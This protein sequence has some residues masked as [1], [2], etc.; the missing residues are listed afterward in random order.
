[1][2]LKYCSHDQVYQNEPEIGEV[3]SKVFSEGEIKRED[4]FITSKL[5]NTSHRPEQV[6]SQSFNVDYSHLGNSKP[7]N[8][9]ILKW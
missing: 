5:W 2:K 4:V 1:M 9:G 3:F 6:I 8:S 7:V